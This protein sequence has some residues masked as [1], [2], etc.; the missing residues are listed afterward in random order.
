[1]SEV[2]SNSLQLNKLLRIF[3]GSFIIRITY[4]LLGLINSVLLARALASEQYGVY[5]FALSVVSLLAIPTQFGMPTLVMREFAAYHAKEQWG[6]M[7]GIALRSHQF[8]LVI[9]ILVCIFAVIWLIINPNEYSQAKQ[10]VLLVSLLLVPVLSLGALRD[11][12]L[13]GLHYVILAQLP[14]RFFR[15]TLLLFGLLYLVFLFPEGATPNN[16]IIYYLTC[17]LISFVIGWFLYLKVR[18]EQVISAKSEFNTSSWFNSVLPI[19]VVGGMLAL[20]AQISILYLGFL[21]LDKEVAFFRIAILGSGFIVIFMQVATSVIAPHFS[22][23]YELRDYKK[24]EQLI[25]KVCCM[26]SLLTLPLFIIIILYS[27]EFI[28]IVYGKEY[29]DAYTLLVILAFAQTISAIMGPIATVLLMTKHQKAVAYS[30][31]IS[32]SL[33]ILLHIVLVPSKGMLGAAI[34]SGVSL[35]VWNLY[36]LYQAKKLLPFKYIF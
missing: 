3:S 33:G 16:I 15:P 18:P 28:N 22:R 13:Q 21:G 36:L 1:M 19:G 35:V 6:L 10:K 11:G 25:I 29:S 9:S 34:A 27:N 4:T 20:N 31:I 2:K 23:L 17:S 14:E 5:V 32:V 30:T 12:M 7:K 8:V 26:L 24:I